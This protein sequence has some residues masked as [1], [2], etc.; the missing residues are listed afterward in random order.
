MSVAEPASTDLHYATT[1][2]G[3][4]R[5]RRL[6]VYRSQVFAEATHAFLTSCLPDN[7][8]E[9][10]E[11][12]V[13]A[14]RS[15]AKPSVQQT[16]YFTELP[17]EIRNRIY[18]YTLP[19]EDDELIVASPFTDE[20]MNMATQ[21]AITRVSRQIR[22]ETL[23]MFYANA[24]FVAYIKD[25]DFTRLI[26]WARCITSAPS[27]SPSVVVDVKLLSRIK[28]VYQLLGL[29]RNWRN[30]QHE[31]LHLKIHKI[32]ASQRVYRNAGFDICALVVKAVRIAETLRGEGNFSKQ[33][34]LAECNEHMETDDR[35]YL[36][37]AAEGKESCC[38]RRTQA[39]HGDQTR[40]AFAGSIK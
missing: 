10:D 31:T 5:S 36:L 15:D 11:V 24:T 7:P 34:L 14:R 32:Y 20:A 3:I 26:H 13:L 4:R 12:N 37:S 21:P 16:D 38:W 35:V 19:S 6:T 28:C 23:K 33:M 18:R 8:R 27:V 40:M 25:F 2:N 39:L 30:L 29:V 17:P 1:P 9:E 22:E